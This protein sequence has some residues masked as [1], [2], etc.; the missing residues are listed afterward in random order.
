MSFQSINKLNK[1]LTS[2]AV[3]VL[4]FFF[5]C[6][7]PLAGLRV[8]AS[9]A[10]QFDFT[11][12]FLAQVEARVEAA[13]KKVLVPFK[14]KSEDTWLK[15]A[16]VD[17]LMAADGSLSPLP[18]VLNAMYDSANLYLRLACVIPTD[19]NLPEIS[20]ASLR[21]DN[22]IWTHD[23]LE[24]WFKTSAG[25]QYQF[26]IAANGD[27]YD[28]R[29]NDNSYDPQWHHAVSLTPDGWSAELTIPLKALELKEWPSEL[30]FNLGRN[31]PFVSTVSWSGNYGDASQS[32]LF[33]D[34]VER[35]AKQKTLEAKPGTA[36]LSAGT[37]A[38]LS[39]K[40]ERSYVRPGERRIKAEMDLP[41]FKDT[42]TDY[43]IE[44]SVYA[45]SS[46]QPL[47]R[48]TVTPSLSKGTVAVDLRAL[49][50]TDARLRLNLLE[51]GQSVA[52]HEFFL[53]AQAPSFLPEAGT[54]IKVLLDAPYGAAPEGMSP[55]TFG[56][57]LPV[58]A[59]WDVSSLGLEDE[60]GRELPFQIEPAALWAPEGAVKWARADAL[61]NPKDG[62]Y[63]TIDAKSRPAEK[64]ALKLQQLNDRIIIDTGAARYV[65][66]KGKSPI[67]EIYQDDKLTAESRGA[68]GLY[69][70]DQNGRLGSA[71]AE[72]ETMMVEA[73]GPVAS[74]VRFE[75][76]YK[77]DA[78]ENLARHIT[79]VENF[80]GQ[81]AAKVTHTLVLSENTT[82]LWFKDIGWEFTVAPGSLPEAVF[83]ISHTDPLLSK[84]LSLDGSSSVYMLQ[85]SHYRFAHDTN[86]FLIK[87]VNADGKEQ[88]VLEGEEC[89]EFAGLK[90]SAG[91]LIFG[92]RDAALQHP[93][94]FEVSA[95]KI[96]LRLFSGRAGEELDFRTETLVKYWDLENWYQNAVYERLKPSI[97]SAMEK[98]LNDIRSDA[99][100]W[101]KTHDLFVSPLTPQANALDMATTALLNNRRVYA[102]IDPAWSCKSSVF[103]PLHPKDPD[104]FPLAED[105]IDDAFRIWEDRVAAFGDYGFIF[106]FASPHLS[107][108]GKYARPYRY[109][110][111]YTYTLRPD[112]WRA[113]IRSGDRSIREFSEKS[114][115][116]FGDSIM[117]HWPGNGKVH[118]LFLLDVRGGDDDFWA[119]RNLPFHWQG[120]P[121]MELSSSSDLNNFLYD[122]YVTGSR[123]AREMVEEY[124]AGIKKFWTPEKARREWRGLMLTRMLAQAYSFNWDSELLELLE[125]TTDAFCDEEGALGL[126]KDRPYRSSTYKTQVDL[127]GLY[128]AWEITGSPRYYRLMRDVSKFWWARDL[129]VWPVFYVNN[130]G[131]MGDFLYQ[132][133]GN[134]A[135]VETLALQMRQALSR[136]AKGTGIPDFGAEKSTFVFH[137][138]PF[139]QELIQ[140][141]GVDQQAL[142]SWAAYEDFGYPVSIILHK[143][144]Y[145]TVNVDIR[146]QG[147]LPELKESGSLGGVSVK[148]L[149]IGTTS[150][151]DVN[152]MVQMSDGTA[153]VNIPKDAPE[154]AYEI[155]TPPGGFNIAMADCLIP[156]VVYAP[157]YWCPAPPQRPAVK[158]FFNVTADSL[159]PQIFIEQPALLFDP[160]GNAWGE[161]KP[162][163]QWID[164][165][166]DQP[167]L[168]SFAPADGAATVGLVR[169]K[170]LPPFF[171]ARD[172]RN[173]FEPS[174]T[175]ESQEKHQP[176]AK[177]EPGT[178]Y[179][180]GV[181]GVPGDQA[182][183]LDSK[184]TFTLR[185]RDNG[186]SLLPFKEGTIEFSFKPSWSTFD[187]PAEVRKT[188]LHISVESGIPW[189]FNYLKKPGAGEW[190]NS[191]VLSASFMSDG[192]KG[193]IS[194]QTWRQTILEA[195]EW[196]HV[197]MVWGPCDM[198]AFTGKSAIRTL[199]VVTY[200]NGKRGKYKSYSGRLWENYFAADKPQALVL[201]RGIEAAYDELR[202]S[203]SQRYAK[204]FNPPSAE[205]RLALDEHTLALFHFDGH[206]DAEVYGEIEAVRATLR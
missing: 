47:A 152:R 59:V 149:G 76:Y 102:L 193:R 80:A 16:V 131:V 175:W 138:L 31:G 174:L 103:G 52:A 7:L 79:R 164:L 200:I 132:N 140:Q 116:T 92:C 165:P 146:T 114:N 160:D 108:R 192:P 197:A 99:I 29:G 41:F 86:H 119:A 204:D 136:Y 25:S 188:L 183:Y 44:A 11:P 191:H 205:E 127:L 101:A 26:V 81:A 85:D 150:G 32:S 178:I 90:G 179:I 163:S 120:S 38:A 34:G 111:L 40:L 75:G 161:G 122:Y 134:P 181:S 169:V 58:G 14:A 167:G 8:S 162:F 66:G 201:G 62:C 45:L 35:K 53:S 129:G 172:A 190:L 151:L 187:L 145:G 110:G 43:Q 68:R 158:W 133:T 21:D 54:K 3:L 51:G 55:V 125:A 24:L 128:D 170:N 105:Y 166:A 195:G 118:G 198:S 109:S 13:R 67:I 177:P 19:K 155:L 185:E 88:I 189:Y 72:D 49:S 107:Y 5:F 22:R 168:W 206:C 89:G 12:S 20:E 9:N 141:T 100:G 17:D 176:P 148:P 1:N 64:P 78:G 126:S 71:A 106:Y 10:I 153:S 157:E 65:L 147:R 27:T 135:I 159:N 56:I 199:T 113:Y 61:V 186:K 60:Q 37:G 95:D 70:I 202:L 48:T 97:P 46:D 69:V 115:R 82:N 196:V 194:M 124:S 203:D 173:Y 182:L 94:E 137:G 63:V 15:A 30:P 144:D 171:A 42:G 117:C 96:N 91:G 57:P 143:P 130:Q 156:M 121:L 93:K 74:C 33:F 184:R 83:G 6:F 180:P 18:T 73:E 98:V 2:T 50:L 123:R 87:S 36:V 84:T 154:G 28:L 104:N 142:A 23:H 4:W 39:V 77:T 139:I 112:I